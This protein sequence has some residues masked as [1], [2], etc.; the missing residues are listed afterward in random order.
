[1]DD[2]KRKIT[3]RRSFEYGL[4]QLLDRFL[5][6]KR[7]NKVLGERRKVFFE[8]LMADLIKSGKGKAIPI[9]R[10][11][12]LSL[13]EF[14]NHYRRKG[15]PVVMEGAANNWDCVK[16]WSLEYLKELH[17]DDVIALTNY[18]IKDVYETTTLREVIDNIR[19]GVGKYYRF[20]PLLIRH[21][22]HIKDFDYTW[23]LERRNPLTWFEAWQVFIGGKGMVTTIH[24]ENQCNLFVQTYGEKKWVIYPKHY[25]MVFDP[26][27]PRHLYRTP[28]MKLDTGPYN[29]FAPDFK[30]YPKYEYINWYETDLKPGDILFN[31]CFTWHTV[32][33]TTDSISMG[34]RWVS[35]LYA[36]KIA[37]L[38]LFLDFLVRKPSIFK[39]A[40]LYV[41]DTNLVR[42]AESGNL[43]KYL[44][45]KAEKE[46][47][48]KAKTNQV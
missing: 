16:K 20:Y 22:E 47:L 10:R 42:V 31:P 39:A 32:E 13:K 40:K 7:V 18:Q 27:P 28:S 34:Y 12:N 19:S 5:G 14:K 37:P 33:N 9:E 21:P 36:F 3:S 23:L 15:I 44:K 41:E 43:E 26:E 2:L 35:P 4:Y 24:M 46:Q 45:E 8:K 6:K 11:K 17:G 48:Q 38:Y 29:P 30:N 25:T 1:M